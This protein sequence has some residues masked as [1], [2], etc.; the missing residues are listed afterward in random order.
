[1]DLPTYVF[2]HERYWPERT[3]AT[4]DVSGAG[5]ASVEHPL[6]GAAVALAGGEATVLTG[7]LSVRSVP[8]LADHAVHGRVLFPGT[9][10]V[11]LALRAG[12]EVGLDR[13]DELTLA[14]P[15][16]LPETGAVHIQVRVDGTAFGVFS[17]PEHTDGPW[18]QHAFGVLAD[19]GTASKGSSE[20]ATADFPAWPPAGA[21]A[22]ALDGFYERLVGLGFGYG[23]TFRG[24]TAAWRRG[25]EVYAEVALPGD[26]ADQSAAYGLHPALLDAVL[27]ATSLTGD[28]DRSVLPFAWEG[29]TLHASAAAALRVVLTGDSADGVTI[30]AADTVGHVVATVDSLVFR[31]VTADQ[32]GPSTDALYRIDW[33]APVR[34]GDEQVT[35]VVLGDDPR[36]VA[37][38]LRSAG[39]TV[40]AAVDLASLGVTPDAPDVPDA[41]V[42]PLAADGDVLDRTHDLADRA[43]SLLQDWLASDAPDRTRL[44][45]V[46]DG[47]DLATA[48]LRGL[49]RSA[50][51]EH[52]GRFVLVDADHGPLPLGAVLGAGEPQMRVRDGEV[53]A[54]RLA[55]LTAPAASTDWD[56][57][58]TVLIT[59]GTGGL[60]AALA[61]HLVAERGVRHLLLLSRRGPD[62][63]G[64]A[65]LVAELTDAGATAT[66]LACDVTDREALAA[67]L[68][69]VAAEHPLRAV[70]HA[71]G[72]LDDGVIDSLTPERLATVLRV[73][74]DAAWH[75]HELT[76]DLDAFVLFSSV[77]GLLGAA[78]QGN[79][80]A[81]NAFL[82][83]LAAHRR[84]HG[85]PGLSLA[86]GAWAP[87]TGMTAGLTD[88]DRAR[89]AREGVPPLA[90]EQGMALFDAA[91]SVT[92][93]A[94]VSPVLLDLAAL[95]TR[96]EVP[97]L[98]RGL[99]RTRGRRI[100]AHGGETADGL[101]RRLAALPEADRTEVVLDLVRGR[102]AAVLGYDASASVDPA[103]SFQEL[104]LDSLT[105]V[106]LRNGLATVTGLRLPATVVFDYPTS[107]G[108]AAYLVGELLGIEPAD[109]SVPVGALPPVSDDPVVIVGMACRYPGGVRSP[110]DLWR[111]V[112]DEVDAVSA[113]PDNRGWDLDG[114]YDPDPDHLGT[115]YAR[116]AGFLH[117]AG[118]FDA[119]F[120]GM[121]PREAL[122]TDAQQRLLL[123][124]SWEAL[125]RAGLDP[126]SLRGSRT[127]V[128]AGVMYSDYS[129]L[130]N[131]P[132]FEGYRGNGSAPSVAS[133]RVA[134]TFGF[135]GPAV[136]VD[137]ACSSSLVALHWAAQAL[138]SGDCDLAL[139]GG[140]T[141]LSTPNLFV[142][143]SRQRGMSADGRCRSYADS[144]DGVGWAE[145]VGMLVVE[146]LS[147][148]VRNGHEI[149]AVVR[150]SAV[151]QDGASNGLTAPN[152]P[153]QQ[154]VIRQALA[155]AGLSSADVDVVEGHGT[156]TSLGDPI[157]A[158]AL[159][160]TY[161]QDR[162]T[163]LLLGSVKSNIGHTQAAAGVAGVIKMV[164]ALRHGVAPRTLHVDQ[165]SSHVDWEAGDVELVTETTAWPAV[166][167]PRRA[168]VSSF[169]ISGTN[170]HTILEQAPATVAA[171]PE[172]SE[173]VVPWLV[174]GR[175][176]AAVRDQVAQL[177]EVTE[178]PVDVA[179]SLTRRS[180]FE[181]RAVLVGRTREDLRSI[182][183]QAVAGDGR[184]GVVF[185]GQGS[186]RLGMG[187]EL[188]ARFPV[189][190][191]AFD[192]VIAELGADVREV[193]WGEDPDALNRTG[194]SQPAL[195][196]LEVGL[197]RLVES[198]GVRPEVVAGHSL[199]EI[200]AAHVAGVLSLGDACRL[201]CARARLMDAL[202]TGGA[203]LAV[204][205]AE[206][207]VVAVLP[208]GA[209]VAA[210]NGPS[211]VV[212]AG[213]ED[214]VGSVAGQAA[215]RGWKHKRLSVS[216]AFHSPLMD[217]MLE[218]FAAAIADVEFHEPVIRLMSGDPTS[219]EYW[220]RHV[221]E[222]V[223]FADAVRAMVDSGVST[224]LELGPDG[225]LSAMVQESA[226]VTTVP[227]LRRG[228]DEE[229]A[230]VTALAVLHAHGVT[231]DW[232]AF[233]AGTVA[234]RVDLP[235]YAF[236]HTYYWPETYGSAGDVSGA[237]LES[238]EH[239]L[240][241]AAV[242]LPDGGGVILTGRLSLRTHPWLADHVVDGRVLFP[243]TGFVELALRA[244]DETGLQQIEELTLAVPLV[245]PET[246]AVAVQVRGSAPDANGRAELDIYSRDRD[247]EEWI[248]HATGVLTAAAVEPAWDAAH[249]PPAGAVAL[250]LAGFY[251]GTGY[252]PTFQGVTAAWRVGDDV[253]AEVTLPERVRD[254]AAFGIHPA[255]LD[256][257]LHGAAFLEGAEPGTLLPYAWTGVGLHASGAAT[258][259]VRL[260]GSASAGIGIAVADGTGGP[261]ATVGTLHLRAPERLDRVDSLYRVEWSVPV[262][263]V[264]AGGVRFVELVGGEDVVASAHALAARALEVVQGP[265]ARV[266]FV[267]RGVVSGADPA[268][269]VVWGLV[270]SAQTEFPGRFHLVD[271]EGGGAP[272]VTDEPQVVVRGGAAFGA[273]LV[274][275]QAEAVTP[276]AWDGDGT[277]VV[278]GG[279]GGLGA[280]VARH[281]V[282]AHGVRRLLL[283]GRR[284]PAAEGAA[285][286]VAELAGLGAAAEVV[287]CDVA[288]RAALAAVLAGRSV[289]GV[290]HAAGVLDDGVLESMTP[291]RLERVLRPKV[292]AAWHL[293][294]LVGDVDRFVMFSSVAGVLGA[295]GQANYA[296]GNAFLDALAVHRRARGWPG[297]SLAWG[298]WE[299]GAGMTGELAGADL[300]RMRRAGVLPLTAAE[301]LALFDAADEAAMVPV[302]LDLPGLRAAG[303]TPALLHHL[304]RTRTRTGSR[305]GVARTG[306]ATDLAHRLVGLP[307]E[308]RTDLVL[309]L[310]SGRVATV[311]G[312]ADGS[313]V[314][315]QRS[316]QE[317]GLDSLTAVE[318]RNG[319]SAAT[320]L[321][322][323]ATLVFDHPTSATLA[324]YLLDELLGTA[325]DTS[326]PV[327]ALPP[328]SDDPV[329]IVGMACRYPGGVRSPE[330]LWRLVTGGVDAIGDFPDDRGWDLDALYHPDAAHAGTSYTRSGGFLRDAGEF[331]AEFFGMGPRE[332]LATDAQQRL[333]LETSWEALERAGLDPVSLRGSRTGVFAG[334]MYGDYS[335]LLTGPEFEG[336]RGNGS[337]A[338]VASGRVAYSL[339]LEGPAVTVDTACSSSLVALHWAAQALRSGDCDLALAGG[340]TVLSTPEL[341]VEFSRQ[342]GMSADGRCKA[343]SDSADGVGWAEGVG[344]L[345][346]ERLSDAVRNGHDILAVVRGSA[347]NQDGASN[348]LTAPNGPSQQRVIRQALAGAGLSPLDV[349]VVEGHGTGTTL[350]DP[351]EA[352]ALLAT[353]GRDRDTPLLLGSVKSNIGHTQAAAGVAGV[354]KTVMAMRN[355]LVP[356]TLHVDR[357]SS[358]VDWTAG[359]VDL[360][361]E[362]TVWPAVERPRRAAVSSFGISGTN[363][364][365]ILEQHIVSPVE[366]EPADVV[367]PWVVSGK[368]AAAL[369]EQVARLDDSQGRPLDI[370]FSLATTRS[371]FEHRAVLVGRTK[372]ELLAGVT[373]A[374]AGDG[375]L[376]VVFTGQGSQRLG[377]GRELYARFPVFAEAFD[378]VIAEL[379]VDVR[380]VMWGEDPDALNRTGWSQPALFALEVG[381]YR[382][383]ESW[384]V[385]PEVVA[386]HS[387]GEI[388]AAHVA[389][390][391][392]LG[393]ACRLVCARARLMDALP[394]G[395]AMLAV[396]AAEAD[397]VA[398][399]PE[400]ACVAAVNGPSSVVVAGVEDAVGSVAGQAAERGWKHK[401]LSVSHAFH[402]PLMDPMLEEFAAAIADVEFHEPVIRLMSGDPTSPEY[403][404]RHVREAVR[405]ADAV[406][407][408]VDS[409]VS[410]FLELGPD[411][412]LSAMIQET[413]AVTTFPVLRKDRPEEESA[414]TA[415]GALHTAGVTVDWAVFFGRLHA[416]RVDLPTYAFQHQNYWP[417]Q[418][419]GEPV[420][421]D[422]VDAEFWD[423][424][425]SE[426]L[427]SLAAGLGLT[428][429]EL[430]GVVPALAAWRRRRR[431]ERD[432]DAVR[433]RETWVPLTG[434][435]TG[436]PRG[437]WL[438][439]VPEGADETWASR[440]AGAAG[441]G[442]IHVN[443]PVTADA[444]ALAARLS[445]AEGAGFAG[446]LSLLA[447]DPAGPVATA[448]LIRALTGLGITAPVWAVTRG[449][450]AAV[451]GDAVEHPE[452]AAVWGL[453]RVAALEHPDGWGGVIDLPAEPDDA[454][455]TRLAAVLAHPGGEEEVAIRNGGVALGRR[456]TPAPAGDAPEWTPTGT[457][458]ITGG[459]GALGA[460]VARRLADR[461][462]ARLVLV[463]RRGDTAPGAIA[464]R[465]ELTAAGVEVDL[466]AA[467]TADHDAMAAVLA[468]I[469]ADQPLTG[470]VHAAGVLADGVLSGL[471]GEQF[472]TVFRAKVDS[473]LVLDELTR[474]RA[475]S[476]FALFSSAAG[477]VGNPGQANYA[478]A[479]AVLD[480]IAQRR[481]AL[482]LP[483]TS[484][485]WG[486][487]AGDGM[488][489]GATGVGSAALDPHLAL[490]VLGQAVT[491]PEPTLTVLD[492]RHPDVVA[493]LLTPRPHRP[494]LSALPEARRFAETSA[495]PASGLAAELRALD[496]EQRLA[497]VAGVVRGAVAAVLHR[498]PGD[499]TRRAGVLPLTAAEGLALFDAADEAAMVPVRLDLPGLR[500][501]GGTPA[502]LHHLVRTPVR[503]ATATAPAGGG[504]VAAL[505]AAAPADR[506]ELVLELIRGHAAAV[507]GHGDAAELSPHRRFQDLGFDSLIAVEFR[508]R[509][510]EAIGQRLPAA[511]LFDYPTPAELVDHLLP[512]LVADEPT[513]PAALLADLERLERALDEI[514]VDDERLHR[515]IAGR[516]DVLRSK[517]TADQQ[518]EDGFDVESATDDDM[519]RMLDDELGLN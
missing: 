117:D 397:V 310:V 405:F 7:R 378:A 89:L 347:V 490:T 388:V 469:P 197:Y 299:P 190:A 414:V 53:R 3:G 141:V 217:P 45:F 195:F 22:I 341:F 8:W 18:T 52:P 257:V 108:L 126:V 104:G 88:A 269:A 403:W 1:M 464:L 196:A 276:R 517:W 426:D 99:V 30:T 170:A 509:I 216:H 287:A 279:V 277:V 173:A 144:A 187:R 421:T 461:G 165:P 491:A 334:V 308:A 486:A 111:L 270:R 103:R 515:Q 203:M 338:S 268:A 63:E 215:E 368:T 445:I 459:T 59:G 453:G 399:L 317:L 133:G 21:E 58:G 460:R 14:V 485:A 408:M 301:G 48:A 85:L 475:L 500:A 127:G 436:T 418:A 470:V 492:M 280:L 194:W 342:R 235:T 247:G 185:T 253:F 481:R 10:F 380:E 319:L 506:P 82:D 298:P 392:S 489:G 80:A 262:P 424:I 286:L 361:T 154:R 20:A 376:G 142:D 398:V 379:G 211:S 246:G 239:P 148:A 26:A 102:V 55:R 265:D 243:G 140:V 307:A 396:S 171:E 498:L 238:V 466:V 400:G 81:G 479:N 179:Y 213:V 402:S 431:A 28:A 510:G 118:E 413:A 74:A 440:V 158:Q 156:G 252:G 303:G 291:E 90:I 123:E 410:T 467:D 39:V 206:A 60:G 136:S 229:T 150:G 501:A 343:F 434:A 44:V 457:V 116:E 384:G 193:M 472:E 212:V 327:G 122:A 416:A 94:V 367:V 360:V 240:L 131:T 293:H 356:R 169:G 320:G 449:A 289:S 302:R 332:A 186:Q 331:D 345:V 337:S 214:A 488:G 326:V 288:D 377:M 420:A 290:V 101:S 499:I 43:L 446:V 375:R 180:R 9:G 339:G 13:I 344:M 504:I 442:A 204:S 260:S 353:Y 487:W 330:D 115:S 2:Q 425:E 70:V 164:A 365:T 309:D 226:E 200:V 473:A 407:A 209:C 223:R 264:D 318:L 166:E 295:A 433:Y 508:N 15:L 419:D 167:R 281:V 46:V 300:A 516:L 19:S 121:S 325:E 381:L 93:E 306:E 134:Y 474:D 38:R 285:E 282:A 350:G 42:V 324:R 448:T 6:L 275:A 129:E 49:V 401:R 411:G 393:D 273:R 56:T 429:E 114:L 184:L 438:V 146:R 177:A 5:L 157:E 11:E 62:A 250:D 363:A 258:V 152:G 272:V 92:D 69:T 394:T 84:A 256:A 210:V 513:G 245:L 61:R 237:G 305:R 284:G 228:R 51:T 242:E 87:E 17:R 65:E 437:T 198:W 444:D 66:V 249:W 128:F 33:S 67:A 357:P 465:D 351:I 373:E 132:E 29:V 417:E 221:R 495:A 23:P 514:T 321:R 138:R 241:G 57:D 72:V 125:E 366:P 178:R 75:L 220:V 130:L 25:G 283:L 390:V 174:S 172:P 31:E 329:V 79:Y 91:L 315:P 77:A 202:P 73:K 183:T 382:L 346:V 208:E 496:E 105:A 476:V 478:A 266:V 175:S 311:L 484:L 415:L 483:G 432:L 224:F 37:D 477:S 192:A 463:S 519:F 267:T 95:R 349:D 176:E 296:A 348:G 386:G 497:R 450:V 254:V 78:G 233:F 41:V 218:E 369:K 494:L 225:T 119:E 458:L 222:A 314:D 50:Q 404:V 412:T 359:D 263:S 147:D 323:P 234:R 248:R 145:G 76:A 468:A 201:V 443:V 251:D 511:L 512:K 135:E 383:V 163:P 297:V 112:T 428:G 98:L 261:V 340:V 387:L 518:E 355:G 168:A 36:G 96:G 109:T 454:A 100:A 480:A 447:E 364:H 47:A 143:F 274:R 370:G 502:L 27:H 371:A 430:S 505:A 4:G 372:D 336:F 71:A 236:Q 312:H 278:T 313:L 389:G 385:R 231:V 207:D 455:L 335:D 230:A 155:S 439:I 181:H 64:A 427:D 162:E 34:T 32:V 462:V 12:D 391:L 507:L 83:A 188:Y 333:L 35:A 456:M 159:L 110:E 191:E 328:V 151:N 149:L 482:G 97:A 54:A 471:S 107:A 503:R 292:D 358:H 219:P 493:T 199:G 153:S 68:A 86:W 452:R 362:N 271:V 304:V 40:S 113:F 316:F 24:L 435:V 423:A 16:V 160:A 409:G 406:R 395:G 205:A 374:V 139:A 354:I 255:L 161:G 422:P 244:G 124:T 451:D 182:V 441:P 352:Q 294:E 259:R 137:T 322:L 232:E 227:T 189:F 106:E 120:F